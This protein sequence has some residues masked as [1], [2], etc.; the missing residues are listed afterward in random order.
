MMGMRTMWAGGFGK[1][2]NFLREEFPVEHS[3]SV[4]DSATVFWMLIEKPSAF[5]LSILK[6]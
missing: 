5:F 4:T 3:I 6:H 1:F 2:W